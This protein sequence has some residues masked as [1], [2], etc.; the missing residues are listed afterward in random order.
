MGT[1]PMSCLV[2]GHFGFRTA[3]ALSLRT[4]EPPTARVRN[5]TSD[6]ARHAERSPLS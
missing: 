3:T 5:T 6:Q 4:A 2:K 1:V